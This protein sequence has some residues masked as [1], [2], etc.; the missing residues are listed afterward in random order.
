MHRELNEIF[1]GL[2]VVLYNENQ[3][4]SSQATYSKQ[5]QVGFPSRLKTLKRKLD[6][7]TLNGG[8]QHH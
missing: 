2:S 3:P 7:H 8:E 4:V 6:R 5:L 1:G